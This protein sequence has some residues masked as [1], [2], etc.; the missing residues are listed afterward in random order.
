[1]KKDIQDGNITEEIEDLD[2]NNFDN[3]IDEV[4]STSTKGKNINL[5]QNV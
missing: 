1:M 3:I 2:Q 4:P 5:S